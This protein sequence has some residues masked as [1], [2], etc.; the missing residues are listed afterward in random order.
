[1]L[2][3]FADLFKNETVRQNNVTIL[4]DLIPAR[5]DDLH[6][7]PEELAEL[8][9]N[10]TER[11]AESRAANTCG[12]AAAS[13]SGR[14][15]GGSEVSPKYKYPYQVYFQANGYMCGGTIINKR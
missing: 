15:V 12:C 5:R 1:M 6:E 10:V 8:F 2:E 3:E 13:S 7:M 14:I 11:R 9:M 4:T